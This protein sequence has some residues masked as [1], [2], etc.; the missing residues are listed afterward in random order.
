[1]QRRRGSSRRTVPKAHDQKHKTKQKTAGKTRKTVRY[2]NRKIIEELNRAIILETHDKI[3]ERSHILNP[4]ALE[5]ALDLPK[6]CLYGQELY[7]DIFQK[8]AVLMRELIRGHPF[9]AANKRTGYLAALTF[10]DENGYTLGSSIDETVDLTIRVA[11]DKTSI[12]EIT[13]WLKARSKTKIF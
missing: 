11:L 13:E 4:S 10:L 3:P 12:E 2:L 1:M 6:K 9:E 5:L 8:A 7:P